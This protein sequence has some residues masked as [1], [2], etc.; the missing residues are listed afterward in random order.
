MPSNGSGRKGSDHE[1]EVEAL[2]GALAGTLVVLA[3]IAGRAEIGDAAPQVRREPV[4]AGDLRHARGRKTLTTTNG[5][6]TGTA[7]ITFTYSWRR[8]DADGGSCVAI[9]GT[10]Q[11]TYVL[12]KVDVGNTIRVRVTAR[13]NDGIDALDVGPDCGRPR[14]HRRL[15]AAATATRRSRSRAS[16]CRTGSSSTAADQPRRRRPLDAA[17]S[18]CASTSSC[19]GK[20]VQGALVYGEAVPVQPVLVSGGAAHRR[21]RLGDHDEPRGRLPRHQQQALLMVFARARKAGEDLLA[22][23]STRR[24]VSFPVDLAAS[25]ATAN[26]PGE[27]RS[28]RAAACEDRRVAHLRLIDVDEATGLLKEEYDAA[29]G[30]AGKVFNIVKAMSLR[31]GVLK[32]SMEL[33]K[34]VMFGPCGLSRQERELLAVVVSRANDCHY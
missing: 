27:P 15:R 18:P 19:K 32:R 7:P 1:T 14:S 13:N 31:P 3:A 21:R 24:L 2:L 6:W 17:S 5:N 8:C 16:R 28:P 26:G 12:K 10:N 23:V 11:N 30:R 22:G 25:S 9:G 29:I 20:P 34:E 33:Y 4:A